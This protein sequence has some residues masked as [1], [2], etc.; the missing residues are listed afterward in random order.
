MSWGKSGPILKL[1]VNPV[2]ELLYICLIESQRLGCEAQFSRIAVE[3]VW[4]FN[5]SYRAGI[6]GGR[7]LECVRLSKALRVNWRLILGLS[8]KY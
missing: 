6:K 7:I 8:W 1:L 2:N 4:Q 3:E 5:S